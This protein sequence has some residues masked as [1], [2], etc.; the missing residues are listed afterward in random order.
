MFSG[1]SRICK[2]LRCRRMSLK[3][4][5]E[6]RAADGSRSKTW[7]DDLRALLEGKLPPTIHGL[8]REL[9]V[10]PWHDCRM[11]E[12]TGRV[13]PVAPIYAHQ[14]H[15]AA[16]KRRWTSARESVTSFKISDFTFGREIG[17]KRPRPRKIPDDIG[18]TTSATRPAAYV[19][20]FSP[21][22]GAARTVAGL[23]E[24]R[25]PGCLRPCP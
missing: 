23:S 3:P 6:P 19:A 1:L 16:E 14:C 24:R 10:R 8:T 15:P 11:N 5:T 2:K 9:C 7:I 21:S 25:Q 18:I 4:A 13:R 20:C 22:Q 17:Q 12:D